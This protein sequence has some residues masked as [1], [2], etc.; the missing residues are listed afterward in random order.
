MDAED[1]A[2]AAG[3]AATEP[4]DLVGIDIG[5]RHLDRGGQ[6]EDRLAPRRRLPDIE[7]GRADLDRIVELGAG[8]ALGR[9]LMDDLCPGHRSGEV[10]DEAGAAHRD[11]G[12]AGAVEAEDDAALQRR[13]RVVEM[14]DGAARAADR[15]EGALDELG[16]GLGQH[17]DGDVIGH[18]PLLDERAHEIEIGLRGGG[19][20]HLD[21]LEAELH[22]QIEHAPLAL[23]AH[24]LDQRLVAVAQIDAAPGRRALDAAR[25]PLP[26][27]QI[28]GG[29]GAVFLDGHRGHDGKLLQRVRKRRQARPPSVRAQRPRLSRRTVRRC[30]ETAAGNDGDDRLGMMQN[31]RGEPGNGDGPTLL[32][33]SGR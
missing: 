10:A 17:L 25:R 6:V 3:H 32:R 5:G 19:E 33:A 21:L 20:A 11:L 16:A 4:L 29:E 2:V 7:H 9:V 8:E 13:G 12:D 27:G 14:D 22:Q 28:D 15:L 23:G 26:V 1:E 24:R 31:S 18:Q 30:A